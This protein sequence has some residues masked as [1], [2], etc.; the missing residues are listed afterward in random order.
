MVGRVTHSIKQLFSKSLLVRNTL[1]TV[2]II[3]KTLNRI[4]KIAKKA[5]LPTTGATVDTATKLRTTIEAIKYV[6]MTP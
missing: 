1:R 4:G 5:K 3:D 6:V 2:S